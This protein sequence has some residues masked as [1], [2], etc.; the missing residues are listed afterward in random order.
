V[1][2]A[3]RTVGE[4]ESAEAHHLVAGL[5]AL[6]QRVPCEH[7]GGHHDSPRGRTLSPHEAAAWRHLAAGIEAVRPP[8]WRRLLL[9][10][11]LLPVWAVQ[12]SVRLPR[13]PASGLRWLLALGTLAVSGLLAT[14]IWFWAITP[15]AGETLQMARA[16]HLYVVKSTQKDGSVELA[17]GEIPFAYHFRLDNIAAPLRQAVIAS[18]DYRFGQRDGSLGSRLWYGVVYKLGNFTKV[19]AE[20]VGSKVGLAD[21]CRGGSTLSQQLA[22]QLLVSSYRD[23]SRKLMELVWSIK[24]DLFLDPDT[25]LELYLN[26]VPLGNQ[27]FGVGMAARYY[28]DTPVSELNLYQSVLLAA[29]IKTPSDNVFADLPAARQRASVLLDQMA[30]HGYISAAQAQLPDQVPLNPEPVRRRPYFGHLLRLLEPQLRPLLEGHPDGQYKVIT[31]LD[32]ELQLYAQ[33]AV[34]QLI[35]SQRQAHQGALLTVDA[36]SGAILAMVGGAGESGRYKNRTVDVDGFEARPI[37]STFKPILALAAL[38]QG[39][40]HASPI[41]ARPI[42]IPPTP[43]EK[44]AGLRGYTPSNYRNRR[45]PGPITLEQMLVDSVNTAAVRLLHDQVG[46]DPAKAMARRLG[47]DAPSLD[48]ARWSLALGG[49]ELPLTQM[50]GAYTAFAN[51]DAAYRPWLVRSLIDFDGRELWPHDPPKGFDDLS[52]SDLSAINR[53]LVQALQR[54]TGRAAIA[55][56]DGS[57]RFA[58][59]TG[60]SNEYQDAWFIGY[61]RRMVTGVWVGNDNHTPMPGMSG[62][63]LPAQIWNRYTDRVLKHTRLL[64][65]L[66]PLP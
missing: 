22:R 50:V 56:L 33:D 8:R 10:T 14:F 58:G 24:M 20:C 28:F 34:D 65:D 35:A 26:R 43:E 27:T 47:I 23:L 54:G 45:Y 4:I 11:L 64:D 18:E 60:T 42:T 30:R 44:R 53:M 41:D 29:A 51:G 9:F 21:D 6:H 25:L 40:T 62:G 3:P 1:E 55:G 5:R 2:P 61:N 19:G 48:N 7:H 52:G 15:S 57:E 12:S 59:K 39:L 32:A 46:L 31:T 63:E 66:E 38:E 17:Q 37:A 36:E 13:S 16:V 49:V